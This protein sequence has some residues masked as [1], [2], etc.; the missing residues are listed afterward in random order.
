MLNRIFSRLFLLALFVSFSQSGWA[1]EALNNFQG[2][3]WGTPLTELTGLVVT[4]ASGPVKYYRR[5]GDLLKLGEAKLE[6]LSYGFYDGKFYSVLIGFKGRTN[7]ERAKTH[8][9]T[10]YGEAAKISSGGMNYKWEGSNGVS[11]NLKFND[12]N[13]QGYLFIFNKTIAGKQ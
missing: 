2:I 1:A 12:T 8:L 4:D 13:Q 9:L 5:T 3:T 11:V 7:F 10:N 6:Q